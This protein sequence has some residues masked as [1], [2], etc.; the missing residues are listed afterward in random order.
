[1]LVIQK[2]FYDILRGKETN[3]QTKDQEVSNH[4]KPIH[5]KNNQELDMVIDTCNYTTEKA[6][7]GGS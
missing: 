3:K 6:E 2:I 4:E 7:T 1:M 5:L